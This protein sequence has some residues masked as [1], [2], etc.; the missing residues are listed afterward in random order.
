MT[1]QGK[2]EGSLSPQATLNPKHRAGTCY[3]PPT[4]YAI[5]QKLA[6]C[7]CT[8][9]LHGIQ[10]AESCCGMALSRLD[11]VEDPSSFSAAFQRNELPVLPSAKCGSS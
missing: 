4:S 8:Y 2:R 11:I 9:I 3:L 1:L 5:S 10:H 6:D 7:V